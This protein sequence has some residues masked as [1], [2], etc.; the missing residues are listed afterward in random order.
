VDPLKKNIELLTVL[1]PVVVIVSTLI[2]I[3]LSLLLITQRSK[4][5]AIMRILG[6]TKVRVRIALILEQAAL[7]LTG[8][9][10]GVVLVTFLSRG[11]ISVPNS[12]VL[13][14]FIYFVGTLF[15]AVVGAFV[16]AGHSPLELL[17]VKE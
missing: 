12:V 7:C 1:Y 16:A 15:G 11:G 6:A 2:S 10:I 5:T 13:C 4:E 17:Q 8:I 14:A 9:I 3:I